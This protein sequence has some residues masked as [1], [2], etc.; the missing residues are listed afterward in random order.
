M[1]AET[2]Y[3]APRP[4]GSSVEPDEKERF[5]R[6]LAVLLDLGLQHEEASPA[7][8]ESIRVGRRTHRVTEIRPAMGC[9]VSATLLAPSRA[10]GEETLG[11]TFEEM[12]RLIGILNRYDDASPLAHLNRE[13]RME[14]APP[15]LSAVVGAAL[16]CHRLSHGAF[17]AT[18]MPL[19]DLYRRCL[20]DRP[21]GSERFRASGGHPPVEAAAGSPVAASSGRS[22][23]APVAPAPP[24][25]RE[26]EAAL[27]VVGSEAVAQR[28]R[29]IAFRR[30]GMALTLDGIAKGY[31]VD[32]MAEAL[33]ASGVRNFLV[34][35]GGDI[36]VAGTNEHGRPWSV[37]VQDPCH[38]EEYPDTL[39]MTRG[40]VATSG[41]YEIH[42]DRERSFHHLM[43]RKTGSSPRGLSSVTVTA[44]T[45]MAAD[46]LSTAVFVM[47]PSAGLE[48]VE[49]LPGC[50]A[51]ILG[52]GGEVWRSR[53]WGGVRRGSPEPRRRGRGT[54]WRPRGRGA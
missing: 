24:S 21:R 54:G 52:D 17:D 26:V 11:R 12:D 3:G 36:R 4:M 41:S 20:G 2:L 45:A 29:R 33:E 42:F 32:R 35:A 28:G 13:G 14:D 6:R 23:P 40:A 25:R 46:A 7:L 5:A 37:A 22:G 30:P 9:V 8:I 51:L 1:N 39:P 19:V 18:V 44:P 16:R 50:E 27:Q 53:G 48:L 34:N 31:I 43:S 38:R 15:E 47:G 10:R 49:S